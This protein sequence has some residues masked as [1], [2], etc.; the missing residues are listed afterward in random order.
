MS[1]IQLTVPEYV[2][3]PLTDRLL[4]VVLD[5]EGLV[6]SGGTAGGGS[7]GGDGGEE[8]VESL[9]RGVNTAAHCLHFGHNNKI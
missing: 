8:T 1:I 7:G 5:Q 2:R 6:P 9:R 4:D 3:Q